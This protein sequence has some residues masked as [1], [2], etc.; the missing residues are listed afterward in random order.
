V[1]V[2]FARFLVVGAINTLFAYAVY[3]AGLFL[4]LNY[5]AANLVALVL[6]ILVSFRTQARLVFR[7]HDDRRV[8]HFVVAWVVI[9]LCNIAMIRF[10]LS[11]GLDAYGAGF[12]ALPFTAVLSFVIQKQFVFRNQPSDPSTQADHAGK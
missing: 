7:S 12:L 6:G 1:H 4:G 10:F 11:L 8:V 5:A 9:Y 2:Q 3:A